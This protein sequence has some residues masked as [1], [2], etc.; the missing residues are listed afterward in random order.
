MLI[1]ELVSWAL[2]PSGIKI[3]DWYAAHNLQ[4]NTFVVAIGLLAIMFP[5][6]RD[7]ISAVLREWWQKTPFALP[8]EDR[9]S[10]ERA[11][12]RWESRRRGMGK[13]RKK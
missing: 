1:R 4:I 11:K 12:A 9:E 13:E 6:Q 3:A 10:I 5:R 7:R 2:G 8:P